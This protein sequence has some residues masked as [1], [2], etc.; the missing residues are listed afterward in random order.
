MGKFYTIGRSKTSPKMTRE[1]VIDS[2]YKDGI[3]TVQWIHDENRRNIP[4]WELLLIW[5][6]VDGKKKQNQEMPV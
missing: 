2:I 3:L 1:Q 5:K 6:K 4:N